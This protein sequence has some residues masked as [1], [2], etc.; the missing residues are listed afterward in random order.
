MSSR[1]VDQFKGLVEIQPA[2]NGGA[3]L[4][5]DV[6]RETVDIERQVIRNISGEILNTFSGL[7]FAVP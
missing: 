5:R 6:R 4:G 2:A 3:G 7:I 1:V